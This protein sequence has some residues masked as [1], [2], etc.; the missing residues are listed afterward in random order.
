VSHRS[1]LTIDL[2]ALRRNVARMRG[3]AAPADLW[4]VVKA[5]AYGHGMIDVARA[6][7]EAGARGLCVVTA[8]EGEALR[9]SFADDRILVMA[10]LAAGEEEIVRSERLELAVSSPAVPEGVPLHLKVDTGMGRWGMS[11]EEAR[12]VPRESVV[13][14][15]SHLATADE[16]DSA[17][18]REQI[19]R[20]A[21]IV[22]EFDGVPAHLANSAATLAYPEARFDGVRCG[23][24]LYG[25]SPFGDDPANHGLEPV[26]SWRSY[27]ALAKTVP[28]GGT[29]GYGR[30][31][32][33]DRPTRVGVV[34]VGYA[35]GFRRGL[36]GTQVVVGGSR[37][38]VVGAV[39]MDA[40]FV[41]LDDEEEGTPVTLLGDGVLAEEHARHLGTINYEITT[42]IRSDPLR[43]E[44]RIVD[45]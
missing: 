22:R 30:R 35:D 12:S 5:D 24:A 11:A 31:F 42:G 40:L 39:S 33:A 19:A 18:A 7:L 16:D 25:L 20:F 17:Y 8:Q 13:G 3:A 14:L 2:G 6:A 4:A 37:R 27:V 43:A 21:E 41:E 9:R 23:I 29:V 34:P 36:M 28:A 15:M 45:G 26:L 1:E 38:H 32:V 10:P 44:R